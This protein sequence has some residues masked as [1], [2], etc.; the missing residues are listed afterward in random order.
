MN[1]NYKKVIDYGYKTIVICGTFCVKLSNYFSFNPKIFPFIQIICFFAQ[2]SQSDEQ[3]YETNIC[4]KCNCTGSPTDPN[5]NQ[6]ILNCNTKGLSN[7]LS[8]WP[9]SFGTDL[10]PDNL[11]IVGFSGNE[12]N[13]L[14][15]LPATIATIFFSCRHCNLTEIIPGSFIDVPNI[16]RLDLSWNEL[17]GEAFFFF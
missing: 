17:T 5:L 7:L 1:F 13:R 2:K 12:I 3:I 11:I 15:P 10:T 9:E 8:E 4:E 14:Q 16:L 6:F